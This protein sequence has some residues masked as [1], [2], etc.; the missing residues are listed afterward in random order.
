MARQRREGKPK[1]EI[2]EAALDYLL[3]GEN[4]TRD[5]GVIIDLKCNEGDK[6]LWAAS[7]EDL[8]R[9]FVKANPGRRPWASWKFDLTEPRKRL[10]GRG[11]V[12]PGCDYPP[13]LKSGVPT[14]F[15]S[16]QD[17]RIFK[18]VSPGRKFVIYDPADPP[19]YESEASYLR[20]L[21]LFAKGE[22][23]RIP[24]A[25]WEP[26]KIVFEVSS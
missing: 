4:P 19:R 5:A 8:V 9:E 20:R 18:K 2:S 12:Y 25:A 26:E 14:R 13:N 22:E 3:T 6:E 21:G 23:K 11:D 10:G 24:A 7:R 15:V 1:L 17:A 16:E